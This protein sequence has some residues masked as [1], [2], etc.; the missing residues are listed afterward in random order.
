MYRL[1]IVTVGIFCGLFTFMGVCDK[2]NNR[3]LVFMRRKKMDK[4]KYRHIDGINEFLQYFPNKP[5]HCFSEILEFK[6]YKEYDFEEWQNKICID[7]KMTD[8]QNQN[9][10]LFKFVDVSIEEYCTLDGYI[11]GLDIINLQYG[12]TGYESTYE[13][14]DSEDSHIHFYCKDVKLKVI[15]VDGK[16]I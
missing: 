8:T 16:E 5:W 3:C 11:S 4:E 10:I 2:V 6:W 9:T 15:A 7:M 12:G 14:V 13:V 1:C